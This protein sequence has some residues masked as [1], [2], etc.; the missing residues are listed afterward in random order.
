MNDRM[1]CTAELVIV[2]T[3]KTPE[4]NRSLWGEVGETI[5]AQKKTPTKQTKNPPQPNSSAFSAEDKFSLFISPRPQ[6]SSPKF[7]LW[8]RTQH[9]SWRTKCILSTKHTKRITN[10]LSVLNL[11]LFLFI[12]IFKIHYEY[13]FLS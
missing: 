3:T 9:R 13:N 5:K 6:S 1:N 12:I 4:I 8:T 11:N 10:F 2:L 7:F